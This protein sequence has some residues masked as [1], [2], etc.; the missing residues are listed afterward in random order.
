MPKNDISKSMTY[1]NQN[2]IPSLEHDGEPFDDSK[3]KGHYLIELIY[4][5]VHLESS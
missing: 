2:E 1:T 3:N 5:C 4:A